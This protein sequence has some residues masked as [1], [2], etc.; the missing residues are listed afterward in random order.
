LLGAQVYHLEY[1][2][3]GAHH[4]NYRRFFDVAELVGV[5]VEDR[6]V[7]EATHSLPRELVHSGAACG[8][9]VDHVDGL[10]DP[11]GYLRRLRATLGRDATVLVEKILSPD[12]LLP[13]D[14][15]VNGTTG[16][17]F[18]DLTN[19]LFVSPH[20]LRDLEDAWVEEMGPSEEFA[21]VVY[22]EKKRIIHALFPGEL[23]GLAIR[24]GEAASGAGLGELKPSALSAAI[25]EV[26]SRLPV[27]RTYIRGERASEADLRLIDETVTAAADGRRG[28]MRRAIG[29]LWRVLTLDFPPGCEVSTQRCW[30][31]FIARWQQFSSAVTAK[32]QEDT[33]FYVYSPLVSVN[34]IGGNPV[35]LSDPVVAFHHRNREAARRYPLTMNATSTH[36]TKRSADVRLRLNVLSEI[37]ESWLNAFRRWRGLNLRHRRRVRD[38]RVPDVNEQSILYQT[39]LGTWP[40]DGRL[41]AGYRSRIKAYMLKAARE[42]KVHT[43]WLDPDEAHEAALTGFVD[44]VLTGGRANTFLRELGDFER[45]V[46]YFGAISSIGQVVL[47]VA[48]PGVADIYQGTETWDFSLVDPDNRRPVGFAGLSRTLRGVSLPASSRI[49]RRLFRDWRGGRIKT[50]VT[51]KALRF[52]RANTE[53]FQRGRYVPLRATGPLAGNVAAFARVLGK[54]WCVTIV[55]RLLASLASEEQP[56]FGD[57]WEGT[58]ITLP[59]SAPRRFTSV[60]TAESVQPSGQSLSLAECFRDL[61]L[62]MLAG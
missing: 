36:D 53:L 51:R 38:V 55:P 57:F 56:P 14:W 18:L 61:P 23:R 26:T 37:H 29:V 21:R 3:T 11:A 1:W 54:R 13:S 58:T 27:Y 50:Y 45:R 19:R 35:D 44:R 34:A 46:A 39:L 32:G 22:R 48:S 52:R 25:V 24:L 31:E 60:L 17:D 30:T 2:R 15:P 42:A 10:R 41:T 43:S 5:R 12:E 47:K 4:L 8:V 9:R 20:G 7:F 49:A 6:R 16:Y 33:A 28:E 62:A 59:P 40:L